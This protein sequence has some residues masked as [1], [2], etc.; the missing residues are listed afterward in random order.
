MRGALDFMARRF[1]AVVVAIIGIV[2]LSWTVAAPPAL[3]ACHAFTVKVDPTQPTEGGTISVTV[4]RDGAVNPSQIDVATVDGTAK[5]G[6]DYTALKRTVSFTTELSQTFF[7]PITDDTT[8]E[9]NETFRVHLSNPG[10]CQINT[11][12][13]IG[14]DASVTILDDD[15]AATTT[16]TSSTTTTLRPRTTTSTA[17]TTTSTTAPPPTS[18]TASTEP[19][20]PTTTAAGLAAPASKKDDGSG[21]R[22]LTTLVVVLALSAV[23]GALVFWARRRG[24]LS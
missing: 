6:Q 12:Y 3:A 21:G 10:G 16:P 23:A 24:A 19:P 9:S 11:R 17:S 15:T 13:S 22:R 5:A 2:G 7:V 8:V 20:S 18:T 14:P 1:A 4:S